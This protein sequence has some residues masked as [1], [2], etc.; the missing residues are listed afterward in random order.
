MAAPVQTGAAAAPAARLSRGQVA[1]PPDS[2][3]GVRGLIVLSICNDWLA[4]K[5]CHALP[6]L[7]LKGNTA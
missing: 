1:T 2:P 6:E 5:I 4:W 7:N 3:L